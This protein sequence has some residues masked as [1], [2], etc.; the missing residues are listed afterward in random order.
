VDSTAGDSA[1]PWDVEVR[2]LLAEWAALTAEWS[3]LPL[4]YPKVMTASPPVTINAPLSEEAVREFE[5]DHQVRLS[6]TYRRF[7]T[8]VADG[9]DADGWLFPL[10]RAHDVGSAI[11]RPFPLGLAPYLEDGGDDSGWE[12]PP[13]RGR[14][15]WN[16]TLSLAGGYG[17]DTRLVVTGPAPDIVWVDDIGTSGFIPWSPRPDATTK[18]AWTFAEYLMHELTERIASLRWN[19]ATAIEQRR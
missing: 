18:V 9:C 5:T 11:A 7:I 10:Y 6:P 16:G 4:G 3:A 13:C 19:L 8:E 1:A 2:N 12:Q 15:C 17:T 14:E